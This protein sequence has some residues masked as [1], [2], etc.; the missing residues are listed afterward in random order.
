MPVTFVNR[1]YDTRG[2]APVIHIAPKPAWLN[3]IQPYNKPTSLRTVEGGYFFQ[4]VE[5][6]VQVEKQAYYHHLIRQIVTDAGI[7]NGSEISV[8]FDPAFETLTF[9]SITVWRDNKPQ[10]RL[11][12]GAFKVVADEKEL[13]DFIYQGTYTALCI[14]ESSSDNMTG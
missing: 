12:A 8:S 1:V 7:Q 10:Q 14:A 5:H 2:V 3:S 13:S 11:N 9:H 6:Q 4:L